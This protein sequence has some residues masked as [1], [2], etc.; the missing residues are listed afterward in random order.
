MHETCQ[1]VTRAGTRC[2]RTVKEGQEFCWQHKPSFSRVLKGTGVAAA[3]FAIAALGVFANIEGAISLAERG[4]AWILS[5]STD[6]SPEPTATVSVSTVPTES[7]TAEPQASTPAPSIEPSATDAPTPTLEPGTQQ[8]A[9]IDGM[10]LI[11]IPAG[12]AWIGSDLDS[13]HAEAHEFPAHEVA[14]PAFWMDKTEVSNAMY[15]RCVEARLQISPIPGADPDGCRVHSED[16]L[17]DQAITYHYNPAFADYPVLN[18]SW[19]AAK[20]YCYWAA[21]RLPSEEEWERAARGSDR[22]IY[23]WGNSEPNPE[24][25]NYAHSLSIARLPAKIGAHPHGVS[26]FGV[27]D[28]AGN[29]WEWTSSWF[30]AFEGSSFTSSNYGEVA[31]VVKGG[32]YASW[33]QV[34]RSASRMGTEPDKWS[35]QTGFRCATDEP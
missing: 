3:I 11:Y 21:R 4:I 10:V 1:G 29:V 20:D 33:P 9:P 28:M 8:L 14:L 32:S 18:I 31:R 15:Q 25:A 26:P 6:E 22:R 30:D 27:L 16:F 34:I 7:H 13:P 2:N 19:F 35:M 17:P 24:L 23:P 5:G 12:Q